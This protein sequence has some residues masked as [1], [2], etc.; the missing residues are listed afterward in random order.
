[1][2]RPLFPDDHPTAPSSRDADPAR[3]PRLSSCATR[4][5][6]AGRHA[7]RRAV[8]NRVDRGDGCRAHVRERSMPQLDRPI[9]IDRPPMSLNSCRAGES[10]PGDS[11]R[12][13]PAVAARACG[14]QARAAPAC[15][16]Q[17]TPIS[18][19]R[20]ADR[21]ARSRPQRERAVPG[22]PCEARNV[23]SPFEI[24]PRKR[25]SCTNGA[26]D[27]GAARR[28]RSTALAHRDCHR[29]SR[30]SAIGARMWGGWMGGG[31]L[32]DPIGRAGSPRPRCGSDVPPRAVR[33]VTRAPSRANGLSSPPDCCLHRTRESR[34]PEAHV[35]RRRKPGSVDTS[36]RK[37]LWR[38][39]AASPRRAQPRT[40][41]FATSDRRSSVQD[42]RAWA[43]SLL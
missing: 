17:A 3:R 28:K 29:W 43:C 27:R 10:S 4:S 18:A 16:Q 36:R 39:T 34:P 15:W 35:E 24:A 33:S 19:R 2:R 42:L 11:I 31:Y 26:S 30:V 7:P 25:V 21:D 41:Q 5:R 14:Y 37:T 9:S 20:R 13:V 40:P 38:P 22:L 12:R 32:G 6:P 1:M 8:E 23:H